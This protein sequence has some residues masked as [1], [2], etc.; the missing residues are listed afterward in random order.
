MTE[1]CGMPQP[2]VS[3]RSLARSRPIVAGLL[4][5]GVGLGDVAVGRTKLAQYQKAVAEQPALRPRDPATLFPKVT[6]AEE[7]REIARTKLGFYNLLFLAGQILTL[8]GLSLVVLGLVRL[9]R[10]APN[11]VAIAQSR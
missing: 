3:I 10:R 7:Q 11:V 4:L 8:G 9:R 2:D 5:L 1:G 6:E